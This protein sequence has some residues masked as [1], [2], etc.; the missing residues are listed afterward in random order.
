VLV[1]PTNGE[2]LPTAP[3]LQTLPRLPLAELAA[4]M[5]R[6]Q[7]VIAN[8]GSTLLQAIA[9][10]APS[11]GVAI[12]KDQLKRVRQCAAAGL[13]R[14]ATLNT[15]SIVRAANALMEN[16]PARAA[17]VR[18]ARETQLADGLGIALTAIEDLLRRSSAP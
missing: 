10:Q 7:L 15:L 17:L 8:G 12:A 1:A 9:C 4:L 5:R 6:A 16:E 11:I 13:A 3:A 2:E 14:S 18:R